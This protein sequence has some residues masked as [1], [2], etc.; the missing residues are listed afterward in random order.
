MGRDPPSQQFPRTEPAVCL[1]VNV[2][3]KEHIMNDMKVEPLSAAGQEALR[4]L[5]VS[6]SDFD[7]EAQKAEESPEIKAK[8]DAAWRDG[9]LSEEEQDDIGEL[10]ADKAL[11]KLTGGEGIEGLEE[12]QKMALADYCGNCLDKQ[13]NESVEESTAA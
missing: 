5:N 13:A 10:V 12:D 1:I 9:K 11:E 3:I 7:K 2:S 8:I 4:E 6:Q